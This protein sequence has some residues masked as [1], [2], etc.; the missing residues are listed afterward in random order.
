[1]KVRGNVWVV[2]D[3]GREHVCKLS[4]F[5][6][7]GNFSIV[8][9][10]PHCIISNVLEQPSRWLFAMDNNSHSMHIIYYLFYEITRLNYLQCGW[11]ERFYVCSSSGKGK[12]IWIC[13]M[14]V[15]SLYPP[16]NNIIY[17]CEQLLASPDISTRWHLANNIIII[18]SD[19]F[20]PP[21]PERV[22]SSRKRM[23]SRKANFRDQNQILVNARISR[24]HNINFIYF[25]LQTFVTDN[26]PGTNYFGA[27]SI[28]AGKSKHKS[29]KS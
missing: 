21:L 19:N 20:F 16:T 12:L 26:P 17:C 1:M 3:G 24:K 23:F 2:E 7:D 28:P 10:L 11:N 27:P 22:F 5:I 25:F 15:S 4:L 9:K 8:L 13:S 6:C 29:G 18:K 14:T